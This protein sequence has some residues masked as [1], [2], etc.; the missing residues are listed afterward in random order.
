MENKD[1]KSEVSSDGHNE[2]YIVAN[3]DIP[4]DFLLLCIEMGYS[5]LG[6]FSQH[7]VHSGRT[8]ITLKQT[9]FNWSHAWKRFFGSSQRG[10]FPIYPINRLKQILSEKA[11]PIMIYDSSN[12]GVSN[13]FLLM[14]NHIRNRLKYQSKILHPACLATNHKF[15]FPTYIVTGPPGC[16][17][18]VYQ[19]IVQEIMYVTPQ[20]EKSRSQIEIL[21]NQY[22]LQHWSLLQTAISQ[23]LSDCGFFEMSGAPGGFE[24]FQFFMPF[25]N[26]STGTDTTEATPITITGQ[27][28]KVYSWSNPTMFSHEPLSSS[29]VRAYRSNNVSCIQ[30]IRHPLDVLVSIAGKVSVLASEDHSDRT[31]LCRELLSNEN[32]VKSMVDALG[33]Y[34]SLVADARSE[35]SILTYEG[36]IENPVNTIISLSQS[37]DREINENEAKKIWSKWSDRPALSK[38]HSWDPR[39]GKWMELLPAVYCEYIMRS[40][41]NSAAQSLGYKIERSDFNAQIYFPEKPKLSR[42]IV[43]LEDGRYHTLIGK[44]IDETNEHVCIFEGDDTGLVITGSKEI[45]THLATLSKSKFLSDILKSASWE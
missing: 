35:I 31:E 40:K 32:W 14:R 2:L 39:K 18:M 43:E 12:G 27:P 1:Q 11:A 44:N 26:V 34:F 24:K 23:K 4:K 38:T 33:E 19:R 8:E 15:S 7:M 30:L 28:V 21:L 16:G 6:L 41:L 22:C 36:L 20:D 25:L 5:P 45:K 29:S 17:N 37:L 3:Y 10:A 42:R 9:N 13:F